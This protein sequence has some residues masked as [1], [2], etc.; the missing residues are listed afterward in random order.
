MAWTQVT[1][2]NP[3]QS[4]Y[5]MDENGNYSATDPSQQGPDTA[6]QQLLMNY[7]AQN[8]GTPFLQSSQTLDPSMWNG[9]SYVNQQGQTFFN[10]GGGVG[11]WVDPN[12]PAFIAPPK[13]HDQWQ[14]ADSYDP[15]A[16][17]SE[18]PGLPLMLAPLAAFAAGGSAGVGAGAGADSGLATT[19]GTFTGNVGADGAAYGGYGS[20]A[21]AGGAGATG[22][23]AGNSGA[24]SLAGNG[25][26]A[27]GG[28]MV[29]D[30]YGI[31]TD[32]YGNPTGQYAPSTFS[33]DT[34]NA[35]YSPDYGGSSF[36]NYLNYGKSALDFANQYKGLLGAGIGALAGRAGGSKP[37]GTTTTTTTGDPA[38]MPYIQ[39][40]L[41]GA[42]NTLQNINPNNPLLPASQNE[43]M[44]TI[45][46]DYL[47]PN[48]NPYF[49]SSVNDALGQ[50][51]SAYLGYYGGP[52]GLNMGN[53]GFQEGLARGLGATATNAYNTNYQTERGRQATMAAGAPQ[54]V[55]QS[56]AAMFSPNQSFAGLIPGFTSTSVPYFQ[57]NLGNIFSGALGG[58]ALSK[59]A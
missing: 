10:A 52:S 1:P 32:M 50:A 58:Y 42:Y 22:N 16:M 11:G 35:Y 14:Q 57:N 46:G 48:T 13:H 36:G 23:L 8:G 43:A 31:G 9:R 59:A 5:W 45:R 37:A 33:G 6:N 55:S 18:M 47:N 7:I 51:G 28:T 20:G 53:T 40:N 25:N 17:I 41:S 49:A 38:I 2:D 56:N 39:G 15:R 54:L 24:A 21:A 27:A 12:N 29:D 3:M 34:S 4:P 19:T 30:P 44:K 26:N